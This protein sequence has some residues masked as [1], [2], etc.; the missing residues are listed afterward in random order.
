MPTHRFL[1]ECAS[2]AYVHG[3]TQRLAIL[4]GGL[5]FLTIVNLWASR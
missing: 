2:T 3:Q 1:A 4:A 5:F